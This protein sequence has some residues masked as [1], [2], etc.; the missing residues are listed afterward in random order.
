MHLQALG[1]STLKLTNMIVLDTISMKKF[2]C[3]DH[4]EVFSIFKIFFLYS[5]NLFFVFRVTFILF[6]TILK[7]FSLFLL[8]KEFDI[9]QKSLL[10]VLLCLC[11][12]IFS[13]W[14]FKKKLFLNIYIYLKKNKIKEFFR[15]LKTKLEFLKII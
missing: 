7:L 3:F 11:L 9:S 12:I 10:L 5:T 8:W 4:R 15:T 14:I 2:M 1:A 13:A 6:T